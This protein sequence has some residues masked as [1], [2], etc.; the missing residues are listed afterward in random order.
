MNVK[1]LLVVAP[2]N[3]NTELLG[4]PNENVEESHEEWL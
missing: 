1:G 4:V 3:L 2:D